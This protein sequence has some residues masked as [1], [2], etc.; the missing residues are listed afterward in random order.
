MWWIYFLH[1]TGEA[2][3][4]R[5][6]LDFLWGYSHYLVFAAAAAVGAGLEACYRARHPPR[7]GL[8]HVAGRARW[9]VPCR[10]TS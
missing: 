10:S 6:D 1:E 4:L 2:L 9:P 7:R 8:R 3:R 5:R